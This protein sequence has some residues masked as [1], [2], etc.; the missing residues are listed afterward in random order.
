MLGGVHNKEEETWFFPEK[1]Q[2]H[3]FCKDSN[4]LA[5]LAE[6]NSYQLMSGVGLNAELPPSPSDSSDSKQLK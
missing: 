3:A 1:A 2:V 6:R 5:S 4:P